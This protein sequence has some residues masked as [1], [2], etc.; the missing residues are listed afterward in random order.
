MVLLYSYANIL[1]YTTRLTSAPGV[2][3]EGEGRQEGLTH[4]IGA[5]DPKLEPQIT[6]LDKCNI[7]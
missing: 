1:H 6:S 3:G 4:E 7:D 5:P 2:G